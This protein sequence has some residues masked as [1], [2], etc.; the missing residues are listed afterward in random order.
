VLFY[1]EILIILTVEFF[2]MITIRYSML[3]HLT[4]VVS[5]SAK[6]STEIRR[7][8]FC[9]GFEGQS[10]WTSA[11]MPSIFFPI[12][13]HCYA[14][15][16]SAILHDVCR[17]LEVSCFFFFDGKELSL[18]EVYDHMSVSVQLHPGSNLF[19]LNL[20]VYFVFLQCQL[21]PSRLV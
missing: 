15:L 17:G 5:C 3:C 4:Y 11:S 9:S 19:D 18:W 20:G 14:C 16:W 7:L 10:W 12:I 8:L 13:H 2:F 1:I 6:T 21:V